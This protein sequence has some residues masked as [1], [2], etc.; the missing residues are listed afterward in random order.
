MKWMKQFSRLSLCMLLA[1]IMAVTPMVS[2]A[3]EFTQPKTS[4]PP[5]MVQPFGLYDG[6]TYLESSLIVL[7]NNDNGTITITAVTTAKQ[8][9]DEIG[10]IYQLQRWTG[11][12]WV[13]S[14]SETTLKLEDTDFFYDFV[15]RSATTGYYYR[16][17]IS[18]YVKHGNKTEK[19]TETTGSIL[20]S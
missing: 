17:K 16:A 7:G 3:A 9:V 19:V 12:S 6:Y 5:D 15:N 20:K 13:D 1:M 10:A 4:A 11:T 8:T 14:G 18:H 2:A